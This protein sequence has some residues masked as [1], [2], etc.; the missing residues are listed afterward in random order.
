MAGEGSKSDVR[1]FRRFVRRIEI[2]E[3]NMEGDSETDPAYLSVLEMPG[4][5]VLGREL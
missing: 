2:S 5:N 1:G 3:A 4:F